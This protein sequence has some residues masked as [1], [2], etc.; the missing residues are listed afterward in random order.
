MIG[1][2]EVGDGVKE[3]RSQKGRGGIGGGGLMNGL[4]GGD[5]EEE[6]EEEEDEEEGV[7]LMDVDVGKGVCGIGGGKSI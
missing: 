2:V 6:D 1:S 5:E 3:D 4:E 7:E